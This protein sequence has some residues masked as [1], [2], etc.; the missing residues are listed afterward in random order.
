MSR[1]WLRYPAHLLL[2]EDNLVEEELQVLIGIVDAQLL[3]A[4]EVEVLQKRAMGYETIQSYSQQ[5]WGNRV[6]SEVCAH[7]KAIDVQDGNREGI[8][9]WVHQLVDA[10]GEPAEEQGIEGL[11]NG[12]PA[13]GGRAER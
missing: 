1:A 9:T 6:Y 4:V 10:V 5:N 11:G 8:L 12:I 2:L 13:R 3:K 7:L